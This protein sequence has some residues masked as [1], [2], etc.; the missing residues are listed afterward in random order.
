[1]PPPR[2]RSGPPAIAP[3][4]CALGAL[5]GREYLQLL[6]FAAHPPPATLRQGSMEPPT[7]ALPDHLHLLQGRCSKTVPL[8]VLCAAYSTR[9]L[10]FSLKIR[11]FVVRRE[12]LERANVLDHSWQARSQRCSQSRHLCRSRFEQ[13]QSRQAYSPASTQK[14]RMYSLRPPKR[15][16]RVPTR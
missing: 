6:Q 15:S 8:G 5:S 14:H 13:E 16:W 9:L 1:M 7:Q 2:S 4:D 10:R 12:A 3:R 11:L